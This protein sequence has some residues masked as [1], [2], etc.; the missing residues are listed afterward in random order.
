M[1]HHLHV[2]VKIVVKFVLDD[3]YPIYI[4]RILKNILC[5]YFMHINDTKPAALASHNTM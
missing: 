4:H 3:I 5:T 2:A 1:Q